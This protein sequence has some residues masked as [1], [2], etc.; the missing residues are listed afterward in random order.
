M[1]HVSQWGRV[2]EDGTVYVRRPRASEPS[3]RGTPAIQARAL[4][5]SR[6]DSTDWSPRWSCSSSGP[7]G[8]QATRGR[9]CAAP[10]SRAVPGQR[11]RRGRFRRLGP[12]H[13]HGVRSHPGTHRGRVGGPRRGAV[14]RRADRRRWSEEAESSRRARSGSPRATG[15]R[16]S[17][18]SG[19]PSRGWTAT[20][21]TSCGSASA[22]RH[23]RSTGVVAVLRHAGP[24]AQGG[25]GAQGGARRSRRSS[26]RKSSE[27]QATANR[28]I[29][30]SCRSGKGIGRAQRDSEEALW[31]RFRAA[32]D[33]FFIRVGQ[34][35]REREAGL[36][37]NLAAKEA[38]LV[39]AA[40]LDPAQDLEG[41]RRSMRSVTTAG[42]R[43]GESPGSDGRPRRRL[44]AEEDRIRAAAARFAPRPGPDSNP[45]RQAASGR[46][47]LERQRDA[48]RGSRCADTDV[49]R[50]EETLT[51]Q[52]GWLEQAQDSLDRASV[53][54]P[55]RRRA[56]S[57]GRHGVRGATRVYNSIRGE[58]GMPSRT[59]VGFTAAGRAAQASPARVRRTR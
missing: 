35:L 21:T 50:I 3:V 40:A 56:I 44:R 24:A 14:T 1:E 2:A 31:K 58:G 23:D 5:H 22:R 28:L 38:L 51:T 10:R 30:S 20:P 16:R 53:A 45:R 55:R 7:A 12:S 25:G 46:S 37:N 39:E 49:A 32:Q 41:A 19:A 59:T 11:Q 42:T 6:A 17:P 33:A 36:R 18:T 47:Q 29:N 4:S 57:L 13:R 48:A 15:S 54:R 34:R 43:R 9:C 26:S 52:R 8:V 27:W